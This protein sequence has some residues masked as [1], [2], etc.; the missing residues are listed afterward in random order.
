MESE[1]LLEHTEVKPATIQ[2]EPPSAKP[3]AVTRVGVIFADMGKLKLSALKYLIVHLNTLQGSIEFE[4]LSVTPFDELLEL[5]KPD[6]L[7][8]REHCRSLL[9]AFYE[10]T[11]ATLKREQADYK[12]FDLS[13]PDGYVVISRSCFS[14]EYYSTKLKKVAIQA[15][16]NWERKMAPP[17]ILEFIVTL[18]IR[19]AASFA[20][21]PLGKSNHL[22]TKGCLFDFTADLSE[23][24]YKALQS[25]ICSA[26]RGR[27]EASGNAALP[28]DLLHMLDSRWLGKLDDPFSPASAV[29]KLGYDLFQTKGLEPTLWERIVSGL[30]DEG[31]KEFLKLVGAIL[32][33]LLLAKMGLNS[34]KR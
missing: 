4:L 9:P 33:A 24:K 20:C 18:L 22:S 17:S 12:T 1:V 23:A 25:Y 15:L 3:K 16:G 34:M 11:E 29:A 5:L 26:C 21:P 7:V 10:R 27:L 31:L 19:Q 2:L 32:L 8:N 28:D 13:L 14:D 6:K 30:R